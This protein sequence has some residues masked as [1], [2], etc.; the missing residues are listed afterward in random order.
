MFFRAT[1]VCVLPHFLQEQSNTEITQFCRLSVVV[2][3][4]FFSFFVCEVIVI[5]FPFALLISLHLRFCDRLSLSITHR[6]LSCVI[7]QSQRGGG[8]RDLTAVGQRPTFM[9][10]RTQLHARLGVLDFVQI[11]SSCMA[12]ESALFDE[13]VPDTGLGGRACACVCVCGVICHVPIL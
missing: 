8:T 13:S 5:V 9:R 1:I 11:R 2:L 12:V 10:K 6:C 7:S 4:F 3:L